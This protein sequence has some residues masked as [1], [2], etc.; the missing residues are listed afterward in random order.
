MTEPAVQA[1]LLVVLLRVVGAVRV[2]EQIVRGDVVRQ[3]HPPLVA[4]QDGVPGRGVLGVSVEASPG[5]LVAQD[6]PLEVSQEAGPQEEVPGHGR[7]L[8]VVREQV[9]LVCVARPALSPQVGV[10]TPGDWIKYPD[11]SIRLLYPGQ[12]S[13][14]EVLSVLREARERG[15]EIRVPV[16]T[17]GLSSE[18]RGETPGLSCPVFTAASQDDG[19]SRPDVLGL[20]LGQGQVT[21]GEGARLTVTPSGG[22]TWS[23]SHQASVQ[24]TILSS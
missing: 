9:H 24:S 18:E 4:G 21:P 5:V 6:D 3:H 13:A 1:E 14:R 16:E 10:K 20:K 17:G 19:S 23:R 8:R 12:I 11:C 15:V 7:R 2:A 22:F